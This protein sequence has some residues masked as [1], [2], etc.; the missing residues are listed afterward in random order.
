MK[1][2]T[3]RGQEVTA[4]MSQIKEEIGEEAVILSMN[5]SKG[6]IEI[7]VGWD[8][9]ESPIMLTSPLDLKTTAESPEVIHQG[10]DVTSTAERTASLTCEIEELIRKQGIAPQ[11]AKRIAKSAQSGFDTDMSTDKYVSLGIEKHFEFHSILPFESKVVALVGATG[12]GKTTTI[13]KLAARLRMS[14]DMK[15]ALISA[16]A[17]RVGAGYHLQTY[18][19]L[20]N[21]PF[22]TVASSSK[23]VARQL[24]DAV[25]GLSDFDLILVDT[26]GCGPREKGRIEDLEESL[27]L[28][29]DAEKM[30]VLPAPSNDFD[31][32]A[33]AH[34]FEAV[35]YS[36]II[37]S[38]V[39]ESGFIGPVLN[40]AHELEKPIAFIT[41][42]QRV[43][44]D[45]E[46]A[47]ARRLG[48]ML[49]R[50]M[51]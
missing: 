25:N 16:D 7:E 38:K 31:L 14:F 44:E 35:D 27:S 5:E 41:T 17:Y 46:P 29:P 9:L 21:I 26:S 8:Q 36:R 12:V 15:I 33:A 28:I 11:L 24:S 39:D 20:L 50:A 43:P 45:I 2:R 1:V 6:V 18:A 40:T 19:T 4:L 13:A 10:R 30:L 48:W 51:H 34:A 42:G 3:F 49:T 23:S 32:H 47:S 22:R 37:L